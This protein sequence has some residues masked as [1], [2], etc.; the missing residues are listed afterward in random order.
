MLVDRLSARGYVTEP[1]GVENLRRRGRRRARASG[2]SGNP[3]IDALRARRARRLDPCA[4]RADARGAVARDAPPADA[5]STTP[6][7]SRAWCA[8]F[9][10]VA[11]PSRRC[12]FPVHPRTRARLERARARATARAARG[13]RA[14]PPLPLPRLRGAPRRVARRRRSPTRAASR[15]RRPSCGV[16]CLTLRTTTERPLTVERGTNRLAGGRPA[17]RSRPPSPRALAAPSRRRPAAVSGTAAPPSGSSG[18]SS[19]LTS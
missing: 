15:R 11:R 8:A 12:T 17:R 4:R 2:S 14:S 5:T 13:R 10:R 19:D 6:R 3:M 18:T 16:P 9:A 1:S 7:G